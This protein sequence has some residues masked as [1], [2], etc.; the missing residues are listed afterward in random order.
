MPGFG[1]LE[2]YQIT[3]LPDPCPIERYNKDSRSLKKR[4]K[5]IYAPMS[6]VG[7]YLFDKEGDYVTIP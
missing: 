3:G 2:N 1:L 6:N 4:E 7:T 5:M